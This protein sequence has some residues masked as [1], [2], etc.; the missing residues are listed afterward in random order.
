MLKSRS[1]RLKN[2]RL[3]KDLGMNNLDAIFIDVDDF[4]QILLPTWENT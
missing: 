3:H 2:Y 1:D 4:C